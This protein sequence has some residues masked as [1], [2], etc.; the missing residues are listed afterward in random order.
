MQL[1]LILPYYFIVVGAFG[2]I[3]PADFD[4]ET[5]KSRDAKLTDAI[6]KIVNTWATHDVTILTD[7][8]TSIPNVDRVINIIADVSVSSNPTRLYKCNTFHNIP[9]NKLDI[10]TSRTL[11][12]YVYRPLDTKTDM[13]RMM[14]LFFTVSLLKNSPKIVL[15]LVVDRERVNMTGVFKE[16]LELGYDAAVGLE[17]SAKKDGSLTPTY[18]HRYNVVTTNSSRLA[19]D[20]NVSDWYINRYQNL[21]GLPLKLC[22]WPT[23]SATFDMMSDVQCRFG[24]QRRILKFR[25]CIIFSNQ[26]CSKF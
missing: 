12:F 23:M 9:Y 24:D 19:Y 15:V 17:V 16:M 11:F 5:G 18:V 2:S 10:A 22:K 26:V 4:P 7:D 6:Q 13:S 3:L 1:R 25:T 8:R 14:Y 21:M 20:G